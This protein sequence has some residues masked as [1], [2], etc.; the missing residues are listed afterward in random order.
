MIPSAEPKKG[1]RRFLKELLGLS[2]GAT[3]IPI[4]PVQAAMNSQ[5]SRRSGG[6]MGPATAW[7]LI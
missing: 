1:K 7:W 6:K 5:P 4:Q 2:A 3:I